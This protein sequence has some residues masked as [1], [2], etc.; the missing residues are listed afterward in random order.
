MNNSVSSSI[1]S[2]SSISISK[3][4]VNKNKDLLLKKYKRLLSIYTA[5]CNNISKMLK[6][7]LTYY[8]KHMKKL[9]VLLNFIHQIYRMTFKKNMPQINMFDAQTMRRYSDVEKIYAEFF[10]FSTPIAKE[11]IITRIEASNLLPIAY[12]NYNIKQIT[13][14]ILRFSNTNTR[15]Q[16]YSSAV[17]GGDY[18][19]Y[20]EKLL[21]STILHRCIRL[22]FKA[23]K[24]VFN[25]EPEKKYADYINNNLEY[26][27]SKYMSILPSHIT[28]NIVDFVEDD[29]DIIPFF[30]D[31]IRGIFRT[32]NQLHRGFQEDY[33]IISDRREDSIYEKQLNDIRGYSDEDTLKTILYT[34]NN[35]NSNSDINYNKY[36]GIGYYY[37]FKYNSPLPAITILDTDT[38]ISGIH[39]FQPLHITASR[40]L[41]IRQHYVGSREPFSK[42]VNSSLQNYIANGV[43][44]E[45]DAYKRVR[46]L[47]KF[48]SDAHSNTSHNKKTN[49]V[50]HGTNR[51]F[52]SDY[53]KDIVLTSFLSCTFNI[54]IALR[55]AYENVK[56][57]GSVYIIEVKD[58]I[59]YI[60]FNDELYQIILHPGLRITVT[61]VLVIGG[62]KYNLCKVYNTPKEYMEILY[63]NIF[64]GGRTNKLYNIKNFKIHE[65][66]S[67][68]PLVIA[69]VT[70]G[71]NEHTYICLGSQVNE[72]I[73]PNTYFNVKYTLHQHFICDCYKFFKINVVDYAIYYEND[74]DKGSFYTGYVNDVNYEPIN[75]RSREYG[76]FNYNFDNLFIDSLLHND[77][78]LYPQNYMKNVRRRFDYRLNTFRSVGLF[79]YEGYKKVNF[80]IHEPSRIYV[81]ILREYISRDEDRNNLYINDI[82]RDYMKMIISNNI[83]DL[84]E[85]RDNF[86]DMLRD[87]YIDFINVNMKIDNTTE[88]YSD[89]VT[90][91][92]E[93]TES[94]KKTA[95]YYVT[96]MEDGTIYKEVEPFIYVAKDMTVATVGGKQ[97]TINRRQTIVYAKAANTANAAKA[98][99]SDTNVA[100]DAKAAKAANT[101]NTDNVYNNN[102]GYVMPYEDFLK[103]INKYRL[104]KENK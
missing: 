76:R 52:H 103:V 59:D 75:T 81:D 72:D 99:A 53:N 91:F 3:K 45:K 98:V 22:S 42:I 27:Y 11:T 68:Y 49:Y 85:F 2:K 73:T 41:N 61:N 56:N 57:N 18:N 32:I 40:L 46:Y 14:F 70:S 104:M 102:K 78:V 80:N 77:D 29:K 90:M 15:S 95:D 25:E 55:Y 28:L 23:N 16:S 47:L 100:I 1:S 62:V 69:K 38:Y 4:Y 92:S 13:Q 65:G 97:S 6:I 33:E 19:E 34:I 60:N 24:I 5:S 94:L 89:L 83:N 50:F 64:E 88:E 37:W 54:S 10:Y 9:I 30:G 71:P 86:V 7:P 67:K 63:N 17:G 39:T 36:K 26:E 74:N 21:Y 43:D 93:L 79:D 35:N 101:A 44:I 48:C 31:N 87:S 96:N 66:K 51:D 84:K 12:E 8:V 58:D 82:T 20:N